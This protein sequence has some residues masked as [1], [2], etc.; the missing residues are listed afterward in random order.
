M[1]K[2]G[3]KQN[4][5]KAKINKL[6]FCIFFSISTLSFPLNLK[7]FQM[8]MVAHLWLLDL[9]EKEMWDL[10]VSLIHCPTVAEREGLTH[11]PD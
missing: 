6:S 3:C 1:S 9:P 11:F 4:L 10:A 2:I 5:S 7:V 8:P